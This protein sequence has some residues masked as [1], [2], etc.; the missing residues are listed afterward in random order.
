MAIPNQQIGWS[1]KDKLLWN[2]S[3]QLEV[4]TQV[5]GN[6]GGAPLTTTTTTTI[7]FFNATI[8]YSEGID[9]CD[10]GVPIS[11]IGSSQT[12][13]DSND[14]T[15][16]DFANVGTGTII[17]AYNGQ[18]KTVNV[19]SGSPIA[20]FNGGCDPCPTTTTTTTS[21]SIVYSFP[22]KWSYMDR[23]ETCIGFNNATY[24]ST[25]PEMMIG[26]GAQ[27]FT[28]SS[29]TTTPPQPFVSIGDVSYLNSG[30]FLSGGLPCLTPTTTTT[31]TTVE[32]TTTTTTTV[33]PGDNFI[34]TEDNNDLIT[35][36][37]NNL[38]VSYPLPTSEIITESGDFIMTENNDNLTTQ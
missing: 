7:A 32:P 14:F 22:G 13:C 27:I 33:A 11:V 8:Y 2:I 5:T 18:Y 25:L 10:A 37:G 30:G 31:S 20:T 12:F 23:Q 1:Q 9:A 34:A 21:G 26:D 4:L 3:K 19:T 16:S 29:L 15:S 6:I 36:D 38:I 24:Y 28:N 17:I 35:E